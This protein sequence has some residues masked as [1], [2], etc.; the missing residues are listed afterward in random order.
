LFER[1]P[2]LKQAADIAAT[3]A[4]GL[5][6]CRELPHVKDVRVRGAV[7]VVELDRI[8]DLDNLRARFVGEGVFIRPFGSVVYLTP[9]LSI[10]L[11]DL[12][13]L[14]GA[15]MRVIGRLPS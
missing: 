4:R 15:M 6:P 5:A 9:A 11:H 14:I 10:E 13:K 8:D 1:E 7:G 2:R 12:E 3:L